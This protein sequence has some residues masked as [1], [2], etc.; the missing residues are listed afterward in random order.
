MPK[1]DLD[2]NQ[3]EILRIIAAGLRDGSIQTQWAIAHGN[4][5]ITAI[6]GANQELG[7]AARN[8]RLKQADL[9][10]F[11]HYGLFL[12]SGRDSYTLL[13]QKIL[14][15]VDSDFENELVLD[16]E[17]R[18]EEILSLMVEADRIQEGGGQFIYEKL[19]T[20]GAS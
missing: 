4:D 6:A 17:P 18:Q 5:Q 11:V 15:A 10:T 16:L 3:K 1:Y 19:L 2:D 14:A 9:D 20:N 8:R 7:N 12:R 13:S